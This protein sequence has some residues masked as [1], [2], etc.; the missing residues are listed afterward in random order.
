MEKIFKPIIGFSNYFAC[1]D[2]TIWKDCPHKGFYQ[3]KP[4]YRKDGYLKCAIM[5]NGKNH[6]F[7]THRLIATVFIPKDLGNMEVNHIDGNKKNNDISNLEWVTRSQ[8]IVHAHKCLGAPSGA[9]RY[10]AKFTEDEIRFIRKMHK[11]GFSG[12]DIVKMFDRPIRYKSIS[13]IVLMKK[14]KYIVD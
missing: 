8:N 13:D 3:R 1:S 14:Y 6:Y 5:Q 10:N 7:L 4:D 12:T 9:Q 11:Q 2:G